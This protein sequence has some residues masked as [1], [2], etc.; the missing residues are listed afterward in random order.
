MFPSALIRCFQVIEVLSFGDRLQKHLAQT[1]QEEIAE[2]E[3]SLTFKYNLKEN[4][5]MK[6]L[7][8]HTFLCRLIMRNINSGGCKVLITDKMCFRI[9]G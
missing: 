1:L 8:V 4:K 2:G 5:M 3:F 7:S 6:L 9:V